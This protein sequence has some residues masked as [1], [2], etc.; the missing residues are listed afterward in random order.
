M[1]VSL[2]LTREGQV[3]EV[4]S[5]IR[6]H[7]TNVPGDLPI[8]VVAKDRVHESGKFRAVTSDASG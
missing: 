8:E 3:V 6:R 1:V 5:E 7:L 4:A 2:E